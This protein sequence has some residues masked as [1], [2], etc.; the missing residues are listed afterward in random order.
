MRKYFFAVLSITVLILCG[1]LTG[2]SSKSGNGNDNTLTVIDISNAEELKNIDE[3]GNYRLV[4]DIDISGEEWIPIEIYYGTFDGCDFT[5]KGLK[6]TE[7]EDSIGLFKTLRG[8]VKNLNLTDVQIN[9]SG[10][11]ETIG[12]VCGVNDG[13]IDNV[14]VN[15]TIDAPYYINVGGI[16]GENYENVLNCK[17]Y[18]SVDAYEKVGGIVGYFY[19]KPGIK[20]ESNINFGTINGANAVGGNIGGL[21][22]KE[23]EEN[24]NVEISNNSNKGRVAATGDYCG[25]IVGYAKGQTIRYQYGEIYYHNEFVLTGNENSIQVNGYNYVGGLL[26]C[27][28]NVKEISASKNVADISGNNYVGGYAGYSSSTKIRMADNVNKISGKAYVGGIVGYGGI[29][30]NCTNKG[31]IESN[32]VVMQDT[33]VIACVGGI[34]GYAMGVSSCKNFSDIIVETKGKYVGGVLG[35]LAG[36]EESVFS[37]CINSG[38][39]SGYSR[40]GGLCGAAVMKENGYDEFTIEIKNNENTGAVTSKSTYAGGI[41]A[42]VNGNYYSSRPYS[43]YRY[44]SLSSNSNSAVVSGDSYCGGVMGYGYLVTQVTV[45]ENT[46]DISGNNY[47]GG[48]VGYSANTKIKFATNENKISGNAYVGGIA[49]LAGFIEECTNN[50]TVVSVNTMQED[51]SAI[52][53]AGGIAGFC[54]GLYKCVNNS[55]IIVSNEGKYVGGVAGYISAFENSDVKNCVNHGNV[56]G[57]KSVGGIA[58]AVVIQDDSYGDYV[59]YID[60][61]ENFGKITASDYYAGGIVGYAYGFFRAIPPSDD[62]HEF[63]FSNNV[64]NGDVEAGNYAAGILAY[65]VYI[66]NSESVWLTNTNSGVIT[67]QEKGDLYV[68]CK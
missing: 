51:D 55:D 27:G 34:A 13:E 63:I 21:F 45:C 41:A 17:N 14:S 56:N 18:C 5:I 1:V 49:G 20:Y 2:C 68:K 7:S 19:G 15:G 59:V 48:Y 61:N 52:S 11:G 42:S 26:G 54:R 64:N 60:Y 9:C 29:M 65:G 8:K 16:A 6:I 37:D 38:S 33:D 53:C 24:Y 50:G 67:G 3:D 58:G 25:G 22:T 43:Y 23:I 36:Y 40:V 46:A 39:V 57:Y 44:F 10:E 28:M 47:V 31:I 32:G 12:A 4:N 62:N 30:E 66:K 35:Y